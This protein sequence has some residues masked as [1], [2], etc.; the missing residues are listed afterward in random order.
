MDE[1]VVT[2]LKLL[3]DNGCNPGP[4]QDRRLARKNPTV[5]PPQCLAVLLALT[6]HF[7][8]RQFRAA[9]RKFRVPLKDYTYQSLGN[10]RARIL[11]AQVSLPLSSDVA[12]EGPRM[13][14]P[15]VSF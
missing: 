3:H 12:H 5:V 6:E 1:Y 9:C 15:A 11:L 10:L 14:C 13:Q 8:V 7:N 4:L 2:N